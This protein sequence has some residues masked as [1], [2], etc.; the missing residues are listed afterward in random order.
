MRSVWVVAWATAALLTATNF[1][2]Q[3][4]AEA[5]W[6]VALERSLMQVVACLVTAWGIRTWD[7]M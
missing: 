3:A 1:L 6:G 5:E 4:L 7:A 2:F